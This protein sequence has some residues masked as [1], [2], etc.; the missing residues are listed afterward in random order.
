VFSGSW[1]PNSSSSSPRQDP[2]ASLSNPI[3]ATTY[4]WI[5][6]TGSLP[7]ESPCTTDNIEKAA[8]Y[9][10]NLARLGISFFCEHRNQQAAIYGPL[11]NSIHD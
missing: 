1:T 10:L 8:V 11:G 9:A 3:P 7:V 6:L 4:S 2:L 5:L